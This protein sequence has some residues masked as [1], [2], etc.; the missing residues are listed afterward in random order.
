MCAAWASTYRSNSRTAV[1]SCQSNGCIGDRRS[2]G[3]SHPCL[4]P[5]TCWSKGGTAAQQRH[6]GDGCQRPLVPRSRCPP[7]L[8]PGVRL[9]PTIIVRCSV[10]L[11]GGDIC[12]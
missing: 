3:R 7:R 11:Q 2:T 9:L 10:T 8:M 6:A 4:M 5:G 1:C 12:Q